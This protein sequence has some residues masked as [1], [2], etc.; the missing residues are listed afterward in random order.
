MKIY[1]ENQHIHRYK[2]KIKEI[3]FMIMDSIQYVKKLILKIF[4]YFISFP[5]WFSDSINSIIFFIRDQKRKFN[6]L[7][8]TNL[9]LGKYHFFNGNIKDATLRFRITQWLFDSK[10]K[11]I[12]YWLGWCFFLKGD[13]KTAIPYIDSGKDY[14]KEGLGKFIQ[15]HTKISEVPYEIWD[16][17]QRID[18]AQ[19][20]NRYSLID[21][22]NN[23][24]DLPL[25]FVSMILEN[26][27]NFD[28]N[29]KILDYG[30]GSGLTGSMLDYS[31][32]VS[33]NIKAV[34]SVDIFLDYI[35]EIYGDRGNIYD[36]VI[37]NNLQNINEIL[38]NEKY[39]IIMSFN[40][41]PFALDLS[42]YLQAFNKSLTTNGKLAILLPVGPKSEWS[43]NT[44]SFIYAEEDLKEQL[45]LAKFNI[46]FIKKWSIKSGVSY[47]GFICSK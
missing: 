24:I 8:E 45:K 12:D 35:K 27:D 30:A 7:A 40:S 10:N 39:N 46:V 33:Y 29:A 14:D 11:E 47:I 18:I 15:N 5:S 3:R 9:E 43:M 42:K 1:H 22:K 23:Q 34:E 25:E 36:E 6:N 2:A 16:I 31:T 37:Y 44:K 41:L 20:E 13:Y 32:D 28:E 4:Y 19:D 26:S 38:K 17:I 21:T